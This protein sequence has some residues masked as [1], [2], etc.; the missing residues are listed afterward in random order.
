MAY[1]KFQLSQSESTAA[2]KYIVKLLR[3][4][5]IGPST[6]PYGAPL[7]FVK[8]K[9]KFRGVVALNRITNKNI[10]QYQ[11]QTKSSTG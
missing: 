8:D 10:R 7:F 2:K 6:S 11:E 1:G 4:K 3:W 9:T 5:K